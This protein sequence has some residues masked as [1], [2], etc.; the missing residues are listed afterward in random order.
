ML[1]LLVLRGRRCSRRPRRWRRHVGDDHLWLPRVGIRVH[2]VGPVGVLW[3]LPRLLVVPLA[4]LLL[5]GALPVL[6]LFPQ[7]EDHLPELGDSRGLVIPAA[8]PPRPRSQHA[9][10]VHKAR[11]GVDTSTATSTVKPNVKQN[12]NYSV[13][14]RAEP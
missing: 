8:V 10:P 12:A 6:R 7:L 5:N 9:P 13:P 2:V 1:V 14:G 4:L 3:F 11:V